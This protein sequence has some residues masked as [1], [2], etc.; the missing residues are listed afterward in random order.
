[1]KKPKQKSNSPDDG[2]SA[3]EEP[4]ENKGGGTRHPMP[5]DALFKALFSSADRALEILRPA[6]PN[7]LAGFLDWDVEPEL[8]N[9][10][11]VDENLRNSQADVLLK[12]KLANGDSAFAYMLIEHKSYPDSGAIRQIAKYAHKIWDYHVAGGRE[13]EKALP[14]IYPFLF[15]NGKEPWE[16]PLSL[17]EMIVQYEDGPQCRLPGEGVVFRN[18]P[19]IPE[20][21]LSEG[22]QTRAA[23]LALSWR[24][25]ENLKS[26]IE[27]LN[28]NPPLQKQVLEYILQVYPD[29]DSARLRALLDDA[30]SSGREDPLYTIAE[31]LKDEGRAE[32]MALGRNEGMALGRNE[33][34]AL[35]RNEG[36]AL[37]RAE[38]E[39]RLL[40]RL[41]EKRF[42][43]LS[44]S[45]RARLRNSGIEQIE[46]WCDRVLSAESIEEVFAKE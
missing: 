21:E 13:R 39:A 5:H 45:D 18:I 1:M 38:G 8:V 41:L 17:S 7:S 26:I 27:A 40:V 32:G 43:A 10:S 11:F 29:E 14:H 28:D 35:G 34:M 23:M 44:K 37:G 36:M 9:A 33:G 31:A 6:M 25:M 19:K 16:G 22:I 3:I 2:L 12:V 20:E 4:S 30:C 24:A 42:G 15:Y 46:T